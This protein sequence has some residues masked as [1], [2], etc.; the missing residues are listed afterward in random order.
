MS[1]MEDIRSSFQQ[2]GLEF[3]SITEATDNRDSSI[4][5]YKDSS[6]TPAT[7]LVDIRLADLEE[8]V[9]AVDS[10]DPVDLANYLLK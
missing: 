9:L 5:T 1:L 2:K 4:L 7:K 8:A 3:V 6:G 10:I